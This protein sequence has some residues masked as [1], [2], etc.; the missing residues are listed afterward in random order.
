MPTVH[1]ARDGLDSRPWHPALSL[2]NCGADPPPAVVAST[3]TTL[4][5]LYRHRHSAGL[6]SHLAPGGVSLTDLDHPGASN[7]DVRAANGE[8]WLPVPQLEPGL[9]G[10]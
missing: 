3:D 10:H 5:S 2:G 9:A 1:Q 7:A 4:G 8:D 6:S